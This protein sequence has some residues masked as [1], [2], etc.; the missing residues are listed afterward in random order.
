M[1]R[2]SFFVDGVGCWCPDTM[3]LQQARL[4]GHTEEC[5]EARQAWRANYRHLS[6]M[7]KQRRVDAEVGRQVREAALAVVPVEKQPQ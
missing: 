7:E 4:A 3:T 1:K 6:E 5:S 2:E